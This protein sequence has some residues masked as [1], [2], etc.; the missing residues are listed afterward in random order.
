MRELQ[1]AKEINLVARAGP[2]DRCAP[3]AHAIECENRGFFKWARIKCAGSMNFI[4]VGKDK[5]RL[6]G[7]VQ[8]MAKSAPD[9]Q[10]FLEPQRHG[11]RKT[12]P[13]MR[14]ERDIGFE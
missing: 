9:L 7:V 13:T 10:F 3:F 5:P 2:A 4:V 12:S 14:R 8:F 1:M 6:G 11:H